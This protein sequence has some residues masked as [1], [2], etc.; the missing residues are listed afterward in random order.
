MC[1]QIKQVIK[2]KDAFITA[3]RW[4]LHNGNRPSVDRVPKGGKWPRQVVFFLHYRRDAATKRHANR[5]HRFLL[6]VMIF[7]KI[8]KKYVIKQPS[9]N[10]KIHKEQKKCKPKP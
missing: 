6:S 2:C 9:L 4:F 1:L 10:C 5:L 3:A 7:F 8:I